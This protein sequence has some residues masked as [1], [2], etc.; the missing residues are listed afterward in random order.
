[1]RTYRILSVSW[2]TLCVLCGIVALINILNLLWLYE[3]PFTKSIFW[4]GCALLVYISGMVAGIFL[5]RRFMWS[6]VI[7]CVVAFFSAMVCGLALFDGG[8][9]A[10]LTAI[11]GFIV[12]YSW[13]SIIV[14]LIPIKYVS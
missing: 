2:I 12:F 9:P 14:L 11:L 1:M 8:S 6:R 5:D 7:I 4:S 10:W 3:H 13:L